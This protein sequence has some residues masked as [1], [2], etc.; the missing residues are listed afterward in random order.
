MKIIRAL[1]VRKS[2]SGRKSWR[3]FGAKIFPVK[4]KKKMDGKKE[5]NIEGTTTN[6]KRDTVHRLARHNRAGRSQKG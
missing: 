5:R 1:P 6:E 4:K 3:D 2:F